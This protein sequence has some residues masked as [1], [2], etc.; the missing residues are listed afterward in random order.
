MPLR[1]SISKRRKRL[2]PATGAGKTGETLTGIPKRRWQASNE[3]SVAGR[4]ALIPVIRKILYCTELSDSSGYVFRYVASLAHHYGAGVTALHVMEDVPEGSRQLISSEIGASRWEEMKKQN[5]QEAHD[6]LKTHMEK[7]LEEAHSEQSDIS[8]A[9]ESILVKFGYPADEI[10]HQAEAGGFDLV[11]MGSH[12]KGRVAD[13]MMGTT[14]GRVIR[15]CKK[16]VLVVR[17]P[18]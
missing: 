8:F 10:L 7:F 18:E 14:T 11:V 2:D 12:G 5:A 6:I 16:P 4:G 13:V 15:Q 9:I 3:I 17:H 1:T